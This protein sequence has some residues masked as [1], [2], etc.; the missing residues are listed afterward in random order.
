M[1]TFQVTKTI[2]LLIIYGLLFTSCSTFENNSLDQKLQRVLDNGIKKYNARGVS[3]AIVFDTDSL[4]VG[5]SGISHDTVSMN[6]DML[7]SIGSVTKNF[8]AALTLKLAENGTLSLEDSL[9]K[10]LPVYPYIDSNITIRQLLNHTS[11]IYNFFNNDDIWDALKKD[12]NRIWT[13]EEVLEY[14][15][16]PNFLPGEGWQYSNTNYVLMTMIIEK[17]TG[18]SL[19]FQ[20]KKNLWDP[21]NL[22][23]Y[24]LW[25]A[26]SIPDNQAHIFGDDIMFGSSKSDVTFLPRASHE[27][28]IYGS[29]G[30]VTTAEDLAKWCYALFE[31]NLLSE[32]SMDE[33]LDF[34]DFDPQHNMKAYGLGLQLLTDVVIPNGKKGVGHGGASIGTETYMI[35]LPEYSLSVVVMVNEFPSNSIE[36]FAKELINEILKSK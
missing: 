31:G 12:R 30:I 8:V 6:P 23:N 35:Y 25:L 17:A 36:F 5:T 1:K 19:S 20:L 14:I 22:H 32:E 21:L 34:V 2:F 28:I 13:S 27:S 4:W 29:G 3:A 7:F 15:K 11:G 9:S 10:W 26:D 24:Y 18:S 33:M 16:D